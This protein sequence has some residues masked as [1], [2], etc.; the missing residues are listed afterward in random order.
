MWIKNE[1]EPVLFATAT[2]LIDTTTAALLYLTRR[3]RG[4]RRSRVTERHAVTS[5]PSPTELRRDPRQRFPQSVSTRTRE[6]RMWGELIR[7]AAGLTELRCA[8]SGKSPESTREDVCR[9]DGG[10]RTASRSLK[11]RGSGDAARPSCATR[12]L[13]PP[14]F[15]PKPANGIL[16][17]D[18]GL[19]Q[20]TICTSNQR[21]SNRFC[22]LVL[23][24]RVKG[25]RARSHDF[26]S[27]LK[28][29]KTPR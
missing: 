13:L 29:L 22:S 25:T 27:S 11:P 23:C 1:S 28:P 8:T 2:A 17:L 10:P 24:S 4:R 26:T 19:L 7:H 3:R 14:P 6:T 20:K 9:G 5:P 18:V 12:R 16:P 21:L 15:P